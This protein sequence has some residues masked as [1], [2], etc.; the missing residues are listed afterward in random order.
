MLLGFNS[1]ILF[2]PADLVFLCIYQNSLLAPEF[3]VPV[4]AIDTKVDNRRVSEITS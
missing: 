3:L 1:S 2:S 4:Q